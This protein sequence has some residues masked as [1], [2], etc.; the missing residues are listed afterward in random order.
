LPAL[1]KVTSYF[2][3]NTSAS[4]YTNGG[5]FMFENDE[6]K[7][8]LSVVLIVTNLISIGVICFLLFSP[9]NENQFK[10]VKMYVHLSGEI[11]YPDVYE[12][13]QGMRLKELI[14]LAGGF[15][16][17]ADVKMVN[18][19]LLLDDQ[20]K[21][22]IP[23]IIEATDKNE[24]EAGMININTA[25]YTLLMKLDGIG[26]VKAK[27]IVAYREKHGPFKTIEE[28][29]RVNGIGIKTFEK[30]KVSIYC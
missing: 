13:K 21:I 24:T 28:I 25:D 30:I 10:E 5:I 27:A 8:K 1:Q 26:E 29:M 22:T 23:K 6:K 19:A 14:N 17:N 18:L 3:K 7:L 20:M 12:V 11:T 9:K 2:T 16:E 15:T 4:V